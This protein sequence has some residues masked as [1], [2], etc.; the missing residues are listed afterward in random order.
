[1]AGM[2]RQERR[3]K[4]DRTTGVATEIINRE[5]AASA[6]KTARLRALRAERETKQAAEP[7]KS[8]ASDRRRSAL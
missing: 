5:Q 6:A 1:M 2:T 4:A 7:P 8:A 3:D